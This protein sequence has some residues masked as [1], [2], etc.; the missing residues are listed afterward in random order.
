[1]KMQWQ[2]LIHHQ[3]LPKLLKTVRVKIH[4]IEPIK[5]NLRNISHEEEEEEKLIKS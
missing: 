4:I 5:Y 1:M 3:I 2:L